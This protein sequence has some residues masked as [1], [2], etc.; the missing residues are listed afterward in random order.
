MVDFYNGRNVE[1]FEPT[2]VVWFEWFGLRQP[3]DWE[4]TT[5]RPPILAAKH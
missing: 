4:G 5:A 2:R 3:P 1:W